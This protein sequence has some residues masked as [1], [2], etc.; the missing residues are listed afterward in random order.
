MWNNERA[1]AGLF[2]CLGLA[3]PVATTAAYM[4]FLGGPDERGPAVY[5]N[6]RWDEIVTVWLTESIGFA[7]GIIAALGLAAQ[8]GSERAS[9]NAIALGSLGGLLST[10]I[11]IGAFKGFGT[12]GEEFL[13]LFGS[14]VELS[15]FFFFFGK[16]ATGLGVLGLG[17]ELIRR[18]GV[19]GKLIGALAALAGLVGGVL[20]IIAMGSGLSL[21]MQAGF[22][23]VLATAAGVLAAFVLT[24][25]APAGAEKAAQ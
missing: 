13:P 9:W 15:F 10:A 12:A 22:T 25:S 24:R 17:I 23:G 21:V 7:I 16:A 6:E 14:V 4:T 2:V 3:I 19:V 8:P 18:S 11:G 5:F 1:R 20:N